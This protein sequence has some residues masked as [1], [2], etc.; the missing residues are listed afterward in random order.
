MDKTHHQ[1]LSSHPVPY[2]YTVQRHPKVHPDDILDDLYHA[3][4]H[5]AKRAPAQHGHLRRR[6]RR[7]DASAE[8]P[9]VDADI[10]ASGRGARIGG[11]ARDGAVFEEHDEVLGGVERKVLDADAEVVDDEPRLVHVV[12]R[13]PRRDQPARRPELLQRLGEQPPHELVRV[14]VSPERHRRPPSWVQGSPGDTPLEQEIHPRR[15]RR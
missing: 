13:Q 4:V 5:G 8:F 9:Q 2:Q 15:S 10:R 11:G 14:A 6:V 12:R 3:S 7:D 1:F